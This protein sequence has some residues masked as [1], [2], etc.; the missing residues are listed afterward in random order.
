MLTAEIQSKLK[1]FEPEA[2]FQFLDAELAKEASTETRVKGYMVKVEYS[3]VSGDEA[4]QMS[5]SIVKAVSE[6]GRKKGRK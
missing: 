3:P 5:D 6:A 1:F 2:L 4:K